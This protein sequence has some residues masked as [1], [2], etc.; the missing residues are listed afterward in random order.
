V[1]FEFGGVRSAQ[2]GE[3]PP[4]RPA[5]GRRARARRARSS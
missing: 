1:H 4:Q 3:R 2:G 5:A